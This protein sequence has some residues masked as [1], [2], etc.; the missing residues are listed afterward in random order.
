M[1]ASTTQTLAAG[2]P[3]RRNITGSLIGI[4]AIIVI[5]IIGY[6]LFPNNLALLTRIIATALLVLSI[7]LVTGYCGVATLGHAALFGAGAYAAGIASA[8]YGISD[9][10]LMTLVGALAGAVAGLV[11]GLIIL[12]A[13][14]LPQLVLSIAVI[15]L[16]HEAANKASS[17]T[18]GSDGL[19]GIAPTALLGLFEFDLWGRTAYIYGLA[20]L[21]IVF[22]LLQLLVRSPFGMLAR[23]V[24]ED[25]LRISAMGASVQSVLLRMYVISGVVAGI[26]GALSAMSTQVVGLDSLS[27]TLSAES[28]VMLVLGGTGS[29]YGALVGTVSF[30]WFEDVVSAA[31]PFHWLTMVGALLIA[32]V[33]FAPRG[34]YGTAAALVQ[35]LKGGRA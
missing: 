32:V 25:P 8:H 17:W 35:R 12:R 21:L 31:N 26:G 7:D 11:S 14:G 13:H 27:F 19:S 10:L 16:F 23:G 20:L 34:L 22:V 15:H 2:A 1:A 6:Y 4:A 29:L 3:A 18:G 9:P 33:L 24:R 28:L 30:M 5:G